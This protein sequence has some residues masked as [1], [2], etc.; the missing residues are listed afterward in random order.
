[1][2]VSLTGIMDNKLTSTTGPK[3]E[4]LLDELR[5]YAIIV[6]KEWATKLD[7][8]VPAAITCVKPSGTVSQLVNSSSG[9]HTRFSRWLVRAVREDRKSPVSAFLKSMGVPNEPEAM[10]PHDVD[11]FY[12]PLESPEASIC[13]NDLNAIQQ[14]ELYRTYKTHW[15]EHNP[16][17][18][19]Y[20]REHEWTDVLAWVYKH[21]DLIGGV[22]FLPHSD[23]IYRQ[24][25]YA[26]I[27]EK[28]YLSLVEKMPTIDWANLS[29][30]E[31]EDYTTATRELACSAGVCELN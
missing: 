25:P 15:T 28:E 18:T 19:I 3:L 20:I 23:H 11:V 26:E 22:S 2:G 8:N 1:M 14:L 12:F 9:I 31:K 29:D 4:A 10:K 6:A 13:R 17:C 21:F 27:T 7:I 30:F 5:E 24:A 16:S